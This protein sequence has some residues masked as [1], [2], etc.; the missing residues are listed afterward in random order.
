MNYLRTLIINFFIT[1][2]LLTWQVSSALHCNRPQTVSY[3]CL[4]EIANPI[5]IIGPFQVKNIAG[6]C[7]PDFPGSINQICAQIAAECNRT[8][9]G[10]CQGR[11]TAADAQTPGVVSCRDIPVGV[12]MIPSRI[13]PQTVVPAPIVVPLVPV[14]NPD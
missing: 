5:G 13:I 10:L 12:R 2:L 9:Y 14:S 7:L 6:V 11:C 1:S 3:L 8:F 4:N